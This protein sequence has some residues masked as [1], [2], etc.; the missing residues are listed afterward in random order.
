MEP[1]KGRRHGVAIMNQQDRVNR[2]ILLAFIFLLLV[3]SASATNYAS[4]KNPSYSGYNGG[5]SYPD[6]PAR[7]VDG[8]FSTN[9]GTETLFAAYGMDSTATVDMGGLYYISYINYS[10]YD[11]L[12]VPTYVQTSTDGSTWITRYTN[13]T[14]GTKNGSATT[15]DIF[16]YIR[17][18]FTRVEGI[19]NPVH[20][21]EIQAWGDSSASASLRWANASYIYRTDGFISD[22]A[23]PYQLL[24]NVTNSTGTSN[25]TDI[26][27]GGHCQTINCS[28]IIFYLN[29]ITVLSYLV[30]TNITT[31]VAGR[32]W[33][34][35]TSNGTVS[36]YY[37]NGSVSSLSNGTNTF[38][39]FDDFSGTLSKWTNGNISNNEIV[40]GELRLK[41]APG[42]ATWAG[43]YSNSALT[44]PFILTFKQRATSASNYGYGG[45]TNAAFTA[46]G[47]LGL[48]GYMTSAPT[49]SFFVN[50]TNHDTSYT[51]GTTY[52]ITITN[53]LNGYSVAK[54]N[55][56]YLF[57]DTTII[58][59][60][61]IQFAEVANANY[62]YI[63]NVI[64]RN[65]AYS[66]PIWSTWGTEQSLYSN[67]RTQNTNLSVSQLQGRY[68]RFYYNGTTP[69][70]TIDGVNQ[71][72]SY[73]VG[74]I[75]VQAAGTKII[76][77]NSTSWTYTAVTYT[78]ELTSPAN[79]TTAGTT[80][81]TLSAREWP[82]Q[83]PYTYEVS[84]DNQFI[85]IIVTGSGT[86]TD[87]TISSGAISLNPSTKYYWRFK[88]GTGHYS[89]YFEYT[90]ASP[91]I[92]PGQLNITVFDEQ[93][94][95]SRIM[96]FSAQIY[97]STYT[98]NRSTTTGWVNFSSSEVASGEYLVRIV[99][100][101]SFASRSTLV[102]SPTNVT[103]YIPS[104]ANTINTVAFYLLDY[105][106]FFPWQDSVFTISKNNSVMHSSYF[107]ADAKV[108]AYLIQGD[109][110]KLTV[111]HGSRIQEWGNYIPIS[112]GNVEVTLIDIGVNTTEYVP[113]NYNITNG[114]N[115]ITLRWSDSGT[116]NSFNFSI[117][118]GSAKT[119]VHQLT[120]SVSHGMS[121]YIVTNTSDIY[122][123]YFTANTTT[124]TYP[125][126]YTVDYRAGTRRSDDGIGYIWNYGSFTAPEWIYTAFSMLIL[127]LMG[128]GFGAIH[129]PFGSVV[130]G[131][132]AVIFAERGWM[133]QTTA[134]IG[135][136]GGL[137]VFLVLYYMQDKEK[138][139]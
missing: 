22:G 15:N 81:P 101:T 21:S 114:A 70:W 117:Y 84:T 74:Y 67:N 38:M 57:N 31:S 68:T 13:L 6:F 44:R 28:D 106:G 103:M 11:A 40:S 105:T 4:G 69:T 90:T 121:E 45:L 91:T 111:T 35:A 118:K 77:A 96:T 123:V 56:S 127:I 47:V 99:P 136:F 94:W 54:D 18:Y 82:S 19:D 112:S 60:R 39:F 14:A 89:T 30:E 108:A 34:N 17:I 53:R 119:L 16:R 52:N 107:D 9:D 120:T 85:N 10:Y 115:N 5:A 3:P 51:S 42:D 12:A 71:T 125:Y 65:Y 110:Y 33:V 46:P 26:F 7:A 93:N 76:T 83:P 132:F 79:G 20:I 87:E 55:P 41:G 23:R 130:T 109:S 37:G 138:K 1:Q 78:L 86:A 61:Y 131:I 63:D 92:I 95:N 49:Y 126:S 66:E 25:A 36:M 72:G 128:A 102:T 139:P 62:M 48:V 134:G 73:G 100:N 32:V 24:L 97:N 98:T 113:F 75:D 59:F 8:D 50:A 116:L 122:Y 104:T 135:F 137:V 124:G 43:V 80:T 133:T 29:N 129:S 58:P 64:V 88:N 27:T 2:L